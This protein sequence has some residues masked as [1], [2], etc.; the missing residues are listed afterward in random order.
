MSGLRKALEA[1]TYQSD[2]GTEHQHNK[3]CQG[4]PTCPA[5]WV[6]DIRRA[7]AEHQDDLAAPVVAKF[8]A[9]REQVIVA[10]NNCPASNMDDYWRWQGNAE[11]R[12]VLQQDLEKA[13][14]E[15]AV[16]R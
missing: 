16:G 9:E 1:L 12:R 2:D 6:L 3:G 11:A 8:I 4:E 15:L 10:I 5:Y 14:I 7:L 13:G